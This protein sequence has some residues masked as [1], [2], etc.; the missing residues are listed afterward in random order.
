MISVGLALE[1]FAAIVTVVLIV[2]ASCRNSI[3]QKPECYILLMTCSNFFMLLCDIIIWLIEGDPGQ[4]V[5]YKIVW[6]L[7]YA[8]VIFTIYFFHCY[9]I[10]NLQ[11]K[12]KISSGLIKA[13]LIISVVMLCLW[14]LSMFN[15]MFYTIGPD[16]VSSYT[17]YFVVSQLGVAAIC[18][19]DVI[20]ILKYR[21][22]LGVR[23][24]LVWLTY[25]F[26]PTCMIPLEAKFDVIPLYLAMTISA[27]A[28]YVM[29]STEQ[30]KL[31]AE[32]KLA[33]EENRSRIMLSQ[34]QPH[35]L[36]N[37]LT[38]IAQ[39]CTKDPKKAKDTTIAFS[40]YL[41]QNMNSLNENSTVPI[42]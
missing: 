29:V 25:I 28:I 19:M 4:T 24:T 8:F 39:L 20:I 37:T 36:Y 41:R 33:L 35:F 32:Q 22:D 34:I 6:I 31:M 9:L 21:R 18:C 30:D 3:M 14:V 16:A 42:F 26:L 10:G 1:I 11:K 23:Y 5:L 13:G 27:L 17:D 7:D 38:S 15:G 12:I 40:E 2:A